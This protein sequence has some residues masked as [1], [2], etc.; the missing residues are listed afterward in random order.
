MEAMIGKPLVEVTDS[1]SV[2]R[3]FNLPLTSEDARSLEIPLVDGR[4]FHGTL[5]PVADVGWALIMRDISHL[6]ELDKMKSDFVA[7]ITHDLR[8]PLTAIQGSLALLSELGELTGEQQEFA[9]RAMRNAEHMDALITN[10]LDIGRIEAG[11]EMDMGPIHLDALVEEAVA[12][13]LGEARSRGLVLRAEVPDGLPPVSGNHTR[14]MQVMSNLLDNAIRYTPR[15]GNITVFVEDDGG[16]VTVS[17]I[18]TGVGIPA[19]AKD[20]IFD[21]F[22]RVEGAET[23]EFEGIGLGLATVRSI[24]ERHGGQVS[25]ESE[26]GEGSTF[27]FSLQSVEPEKP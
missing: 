6:K 11:L 19:Q 1:E 22:Y 16:Q 7:T 10:L 26:E 3:L 2:D 20:R 13:L 27:S 8:S 5:S 24:V 25:M 17:V 15:G 9:E 21:K 12:N 4:T 23:R 14:L 18:D